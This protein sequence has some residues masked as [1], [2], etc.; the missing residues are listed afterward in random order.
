MYIEKDECA[1]ASAMAR[2]KEGKTHAQSWWTP[3]GRQPLCFS[4]LSPSRVSSPLSLLAALHLLYTTP[5]KSPL[6]LWCRRRMHRHTRVAWEPT[7]FAS[8]RLSHHP[9]FLSLRHFCL[10]SRRR[11]SVA[12]HAALCRSHWRAILYINIFFF[13]KLMYNFS[14][15]F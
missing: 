11:R 13:F 7:L 8:I 3:I 6:G 1:P 15:I 4:T 9:S 2:R 5:P 14:F 10:P 12:R